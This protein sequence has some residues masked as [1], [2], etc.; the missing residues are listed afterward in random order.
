[1]EAS[2]IRDCLGFKPCLDCFNLGLIYHD[3]LF[4]DDMPKEYH[5]PIKNSHFSNL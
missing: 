1:M 4:K 5:T 2:Y 3:F